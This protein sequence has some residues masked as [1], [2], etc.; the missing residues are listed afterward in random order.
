LPYFVEIRYVDV[1]RVSGGS[2]MVRINLRS[3]P[4]MMDSADIGNG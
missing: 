4:R 2:G 3:N 1:L